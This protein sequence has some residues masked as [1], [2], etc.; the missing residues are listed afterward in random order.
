MLPYIKKKILQCTCVAFIIRKWH[1]STSTYKWFSYYCFMNR[2]WF[3]LIVN[4]T[5][6]LEKSWGPCHNINIYFIKYLFYL[7]YTEDN[8]HKTN[9]NLNIRYTLMYINLDHCY[10]QDTWKLF[11]NFTKKLFYFLWRNGG[12]TMQT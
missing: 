6:I 2:F 5:K 12:V 8:L 3:Q 10:V 1:N 7:Q 4:H 9:H 11:R